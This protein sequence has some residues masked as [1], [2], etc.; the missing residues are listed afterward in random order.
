[1]MEAVF[2]RIKLEFGRRMAPREVDPTMQESWAELDE[3]DLV[4]I[5]RIPMLRVAP[6]GR[7]RNS[8]TALEDRREAERDGDQVAVERAGFGRFV[9]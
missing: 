5:R 9:F 2:V 3:V 8:F 7:L 6:R 1:M 4:F